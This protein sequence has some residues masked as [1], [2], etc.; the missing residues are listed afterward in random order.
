MDAKQKKWLW[1]SIGLSMVILL[2]VAAFTFD[3]NTVESLKNLNPWYLLLAFG[4]AHG[5]DVCGHSVS[6]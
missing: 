5:C 2:G 3:E 4:L 1:V 6:E